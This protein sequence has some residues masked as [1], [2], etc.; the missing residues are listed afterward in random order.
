MQC[1]HCGTTLQA[2]DFP[3]EASWGKHHYVCFNDDCSYYEEGWTW[4]WEQYSARAS[5]RF[6]VVNLETGVTSPLPV[7]SKDAL[8]DRIVEDAAAS[9]ETMDPP[10]NDASQENSNS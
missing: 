10:A 7:W 3:E 5:Y 4:M 6:R 2:I 1:P 9:S 8:R